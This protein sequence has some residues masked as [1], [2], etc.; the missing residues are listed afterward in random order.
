[1]QI[2]IHIIL[3]NVYCAAHTEMY[4]SYLLDIFSFEFFDPAEWISDSFNI[5][6]NGPM[7]EHFEST[8]YERSDFILNMGLLF[9]VALAIVPLILLMLLSSSRVFCCMPRY[10][11][12]CRK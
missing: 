4:I 8:G 2:L 11:S 10:Q 6:E 3:I 12:C 1:M 7:N 5:Q 9:L